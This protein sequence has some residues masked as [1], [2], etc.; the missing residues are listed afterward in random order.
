MSRRLPA[1]TTPINADFFTVQ[2]SL[3]IDLVVGL[4]EQVG[5]APDRA[6]HRPGAVA[7]NITYGIKNK[8]ANHASSLSVPEISAHISAHGDERSAER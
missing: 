1:R 5:G 6:D 3:R 2:E 7:Q 4:D 8:P